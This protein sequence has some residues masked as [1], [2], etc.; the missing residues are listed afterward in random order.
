MYFSVVGSND[1]SKTIDLKTSSFPNTII[2][3]INYDT[4]DTY[5]DQYGD[6][7]LIYSKYGSPNKD[8]VSGDKSN[9]F[10]TIIEKK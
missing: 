2:I 8:S 7:N 9:I 3:R 10:F 1:I 4:L 5:K 6:A